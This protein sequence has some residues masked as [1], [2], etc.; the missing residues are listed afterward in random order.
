MAD[1]KTFSDYQAAFFLCKEQNEAIHTWMKEHDQARHIDPKR[2]HRYSGAIGGAY[3]FCFTPTSLGTVATV[4]CACGE[5][6]DVTDYD[7]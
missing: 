2:G 6:F 4:E 3:T 5:K 7:W 1:I